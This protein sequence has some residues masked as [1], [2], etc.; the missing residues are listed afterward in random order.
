LIVLSN[1]RL[2]NCSTVAPTTAPTDDLF[3]FTL[4]VVA[5][6]ALNISIEVCGDTNVTSPKTEAYAFDTVIRMFA[7]T[8]FN[9]PPP[10]A[11]TCWCPKD[12]AVIADE[13]LPTRVEVNLVPLFNIDDSD[14]AE[15]VKVLTRVPAVTAFPTNVDIIAIVQLAKVKS[16]MRVRSLNKLP[17][18]VA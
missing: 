18:V 4:T 9:S 1:G 13:I 3:T 2:N 5:G 11:K 14:I 16:S 17:T 8:T 10:I 15:D 12:S 6:T 7:V